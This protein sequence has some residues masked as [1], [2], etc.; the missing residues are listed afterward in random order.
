MSSQARVNAEGVTVSGAPAQPVEK[1]ETPPRRYDLDWL[2]V[3]VIIILIPFHA[4][5]MFDPGG[6]FYVRNAASSRLLAG[7]TDAVGAW[8]MQ[9]LFFVAGASCW[10]ALRKHRWR[11]FVGERA[12]RL[13]LPL[14]V[15]ILTINPLMGYFG[16]LFHGGAGASFWAYYP[17]FFKFSAEDYTGYA[18]HLTPAH[19]WFV[20]FLFVLILAASPLFLWLNRTRGRRF[21]ARLAGLLSKPGAFLLAPVVMLFLDALPDVAERNIF[22]FLFFLIAGFIWMAEPRLQ[23]S[24]DRQKY[25][26]LAVSLATGVLFIALQSWSGGREPFTLGSSLFDLLHDTYAWTT[27]LWLLAFGRAFL[28]RPGRAVAYLGRASYA[29][30]IIHLP[31]VVTIGYYVVKWDA[32]VGLKYAVIVIASLAA[33]WLNYDLL[34]RRV[35]VIGRLLGLKPEGRG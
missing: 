25:L 16:R 7:F 34:V 2:R 10:F 32:G 29:I 28:N 22:A 33:T 17:H 14:A 6:D 26:L 9:L 4:A 1:A 5:V 15:A 12:L 20:L 23:D 18:G 31:I 35:A 8:G 13:I 3:A 27:T 24:V 19:L 30:Y 11:R 21:T